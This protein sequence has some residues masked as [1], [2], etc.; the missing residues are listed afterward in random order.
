MNDCYEQ[1]EMQMSLFR[2]TFTLTVWKRAAGTFIKTSSVSVRVW[3]D[4]EPS[5]DTSGLLR[6][7]QLV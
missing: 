7:I 2:V 4:G 6:H 5:H 1:F 3:I